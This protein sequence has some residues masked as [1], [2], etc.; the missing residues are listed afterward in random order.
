M[1]S[2]VL[3]V[4]IERCVIVFQIWG[5]SNS[6]WELRRQRP[7]LKKLKKLLMEN[8]YDGPAVGMQEETPG[9]KVH[10]VSEPVLTI[11]IGIIHG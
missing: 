11:Y 6:Y 2:I 3:I 5:F 8:P 9:E 4:Y 10:Q 7:R 1:E